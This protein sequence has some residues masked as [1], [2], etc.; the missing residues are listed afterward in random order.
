M[1]YFAPA[2]AAA[3]LVGL[4]AAA[5][6]QNYAPMGP[7]MM[8]PPAPYLPRYMMDDGSSSDFPTH[9]PSDFVADHLNQQI[10]E[11]NEGSGPMAPAPYPLGF[12]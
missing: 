12:R 7:Q 1:K 10:H 6:A 2:F 3:A 5:T 9:T 4:V 8:A 11:M